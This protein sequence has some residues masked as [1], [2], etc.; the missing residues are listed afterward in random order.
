VPTPLHDIEVLRALA[1]SAEGSA[2]DWATVRLALREPGALS[3]LPDNGWDASLCLA[4]APDQGAPL[5]LAALAADRPGR[6]V[7]LADRL[8][9]LGHRPDDPQPWIAALRAAELPTGHRGALSVGRALADLG[10]LDAD[11]LSRCTAVPVTNDEVRAGL[12][13]L[14]LRFAAA[15]GHP[16]DE[17]AAQVAG[18][19]HD[20]VTA[21]PTLVGR[22]LTWLGAPALLPLASD[23]PGDPARRAAAAAGGELPALPSVRGS[24]R[25]RAQRQVRALLREVEGPAAALL[26]ALA[27]RPDAPL[28]AITTHAAWLAV[29]TPPSDAVEAVLRGAGEDRAV[30]AAARAQVTAEHAP[31]LA[32]HILD[33]SWETCPAAVPA[34]ALLLRSPDDQGALARALLGRGMID[35]GRDDRLDLACVIAA[36]RHPESVPHL[37]AE[38]ETRDTGLAMARFVGTEEVLQALLELPVPADPT[39]RGLYALALAE[40]ADPAIEAPLRALAADDDSPVVGSAVRRAEALFGRPLHSG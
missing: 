22:V 10:G 7:H 37:L 19:L 14:V 27:S 12:V 11:A 25:R 2:R 6:A 23:A 16:L 3:R 4:C 38:A 13:A 33:P 39:S 26:R 35:M 36:A 8:L 1:E 34:A 17:V 5:V 30:L 28:Q 31:R 18:R 40:L 21:D 29:Y 20:G 32:E 24:A 9:A 15:H